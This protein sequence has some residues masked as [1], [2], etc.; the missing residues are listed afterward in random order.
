MD[1]LKDELGIAFLR[2]LENTFRTVQVARLVP[3]EFGHE[4]VELR[5]N[6]RFVRREAQRAHPR[7][8]MLLLA[9]LR[10]RVVMLMR[11]GN[12]S[13][14]LV[15]IHLLLVAVFVGI[16]VAM[17][18][19]LFIVAVAVALLRF[20][21]LL[22]VELIQGAIK[23]LHGE[24]VHVEN[25]FEVHA[26]A[27]RLNQLRERVDGCDSFLQVNQ[28]LLRDEIDLVHEDLVR[29]CNLRDRLVDGIV[30]A[31]LVDV[32][33][34]ELAVDEADDAVDAEVVGD[35]RVLGESRYYWRRVC[36]SRRLHEDKVKVALAVL[37]LRERLHQ[38]ATHRTTRTTV[39]EADHLLG[40][41]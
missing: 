30:F 34:D 14:A 26:R 18:R 38:V 39:V 6:Q 32:L 2:E 19:H 29:K 27:L 24:R 22:H 31:L 10:H 9:L 13:C 36:K 5:A 7:Q 40:N 4:A 17:L 3:K 33:R 11:C 8:I 23:S 41:L 37:E 21:E 28:L 35:D 12:R 1:S 25:L 15:A 20:F 16:L